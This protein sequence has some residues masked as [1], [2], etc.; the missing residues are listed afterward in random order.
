MSF[1]EILKTEVLKRIEKCADVETQ[2][3]TKELI[4]YL[5]SEI[6]RIDYEADKLSEWMSFINTHPK[7]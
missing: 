4:E 3:L 2:K 6:K 7:K 1:K 5:E